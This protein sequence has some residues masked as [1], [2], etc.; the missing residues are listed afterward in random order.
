MAD[1]ERALLGVTRD[2]VLRKRLRPWVGVIRR[3]LRDRPVVVAPG[4]LLVAETPSRRNAGAHYTPRDARR[5]G[6]AAR[7]GT[8][9]LPARPAPERRPGHLAAGLVGRAARPQGRRHRLRL[10][11]VPRR[12]R[13]LPR[14]PARRGLAPGGHGHP[15]PARAGGRGAAQGRR[16]V[17]VR[18]GHQRHGRRDVQAVAVAGVARPGPA[19]RVRRRQGAARQLAARGDQPAPA[20]GAAHRAQAVPAQ[21]R[22]EIGRPPVRRAAGHRPRRRAGDCLAPLAGHGDQRGGPAAHRAPPSAASYASSNGSPRT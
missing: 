17:P 6:R 16:D 7:P 9:R 12:G 2:E 19:V 15:A 22:F 1:A 13:A 14:R 11:R 18:G 10:R 4:G 20:R 5:G 8:A 21:R 3:D